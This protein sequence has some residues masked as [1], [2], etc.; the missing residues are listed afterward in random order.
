MRSERVQILLIEDNPGDAQLLREMLIRAGSIGLVNTEFELICAE[1]LDHGLTRLAE[2]K[3]DVVLLDLSLPECEGLDALL[4]IREQS[5]TAAILVLTEFD[6]HELAIR[7]V[8]SGAQDYMVKW[9]FAAGAV[10]V[11][12]IRYAIE[13]QRLLHELRQTRDAAL[14]SV[15]LKS[16]FL[17]NM[18]HEIR[19]PMNAVIG[20]AGLL[21]DTRLTMDQYEY[22]ETI[23][24]SA[25][26]LLKIL[27]DIL[28][29]SKIEAGKL[30]MEICSFDL[31]HA[32]DETVEVLA[33]QATLKG[34][35]LVSLIYSDVP[36][37]LR[38]DRG[39]LRQVL[40]NLIDNALKFTERGEVIVRVTKES[41][42]ENDVRVRF[43]VTDTGIGISKE[44][45]SLL[46]RAF[47]QVDGSAT[48]R[49]GGTGMG[50]VIAKELVELMKGE[51]GFLSEPGRGSTFWFTIPLE[52]ERLEAASAS[53]RHA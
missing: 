9:D 22:A 12:A 52:K 36:N 26:A 34:L 30:K 47:T 45:K 18:S 14:E 35:E 20:M 53:G 2:I 23:R 13:R 3:T 24:T 33:G 42:D 49:H 39:R 27:N 5:P 11:R 8:Q 19:T 28:D 16:E 29:F 38:G 50:L 46:F 31:Q 15:R 43:A 7:A 40:V 25:N 4:K 48:R 17:T 6:D 41:E 37:S 44:T 10:L 1:R 51:I 32:M 21:L